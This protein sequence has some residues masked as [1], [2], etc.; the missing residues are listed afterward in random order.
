MRISRCIRLACRAAVVLALGACSGQIDPAQ[1]IVGG[2]GAG[3]ANHGGPD[4]DGDSPDG[5][6]SLPGQDPT[7]PGA[8]PN[9]DGAGDDEPAPVTCT[10]LGTVG[11][12]VPLR[13]LTAAQ[14]ERSAD[15][16]L[17]VKR[18]LPV[19]DEKLFT[20][21]S[22]ISTPIDASAARGYLDFAEGAIASADL[23]RCASD[24]D[25][26]LTWLLDDV[27]LRLFRRPLGTEQRAR[28]TSLFQL[29]MGTD[30]P[31]P[32]DGARWVLE[33]MLQSPSFTYLD[34]VVDADGYLD[35]YSLASR[36]AL[37]LWGSNPD[38][39][40]LARASEGQLASPDDIREE[41]TRMLADPRSRDG[42]R[43]FVDQWLE[44]EL[45]DDADSRP[46]LA[47]LGE[48]TLHALREEPVA[49]FASLL[50]QG[51]G[52]R[53][54][55]TTSQTVRLDPL[56]EIY[57]A[58]IV[59]T[60]VDAF[61]LD[62]TR[63]AGILTLPGVMAALA[64]AGTTSPTRRGYAVLSSLLCTPPAPP[65]PGVNVTL[66]EVGPD[67]T[68][69]ERLE[70]HFSDDVC[71]SCHRQMDGIGF[72]FEGI[73]W[74]GKSRDDDHGKAIDDVT[75]FV[76]GGEEVNVDGSPQ[77]AAAMANDEA[78]ATCVA[79][80]WASYATGVPATDDAECLVQALG[81][82][83]P[84]EGGLGTMMMTYL[85]SDWFRRGGQP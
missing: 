29:G 2:G 40:L 85:T 14:V 20:Y 23:A 55:L 68:A 34:E 59:G 61:E 71:G 60:S 45:L 65:P 27:G 84:E 7:K 77:L 17:G 6:S 56:T 62:P 33:A 39:E 25:A 42:L 76:L 51:K 48:E 24:R 53:D 13:R 15:A 74:L 3:G 75:M 12:P 19:T 22:N 72:A 78:V 32:S 63:R 5:P 38:S 57:G 44:L 16:V 73:D 43:D 66:P 49:L 10:D 11:A 52:L 83:L 41:A 35:P 64:H 36:M 30:A 79:S 80:Q 81:K 31:K 82:E 50:E 37:V 54:L 46:D 58:D 18:M 8:L 69:R 9:D 21:R 4:G 1:S 70:A 67:A 47:A 26:C 28:Y